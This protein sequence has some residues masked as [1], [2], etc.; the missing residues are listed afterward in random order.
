MLYEQKSL[1][2]G[3]KVDEPARVRFPD[4]GLKYLIGLE[5][6]NVNGHRL[7]MDAFYPKNATEK[8]PAVIWIHGGG[9]SSEE[10]TRFY[11]PEVQLA[12]LARQGFFVASIDYRL[13]QQAIFPAQIEDCKCA[14]RYL[15]AHA[16]EYGI[17]KDHIAVWGESAGGHL[18]GLMACT[19]GYAP[20]EGNGGWENESSDVQA[21]VPWY[22]PVELK[23][24]EGTLFERMFGGM[25]E[26]AQALA[27]AASPIT[28]AQKKDLPPMLLMHGN[29]D[30]IVS[31]SNSEE[32]L[33][34]ALEVNNPVR[35]ITVINQGHGFF[36]GDE[37]YQAIYDFLW[38][39]LKGKDRHAINYAGDGGH[40]VFY[41]PTDWDKEGVDYLKDVTYSHAGGY[42]L[43]MDIFL[44]R[45]GKK[46]RPTVLW[47]HGGGLRSEEL[48]RLYR[49][50]E[51]MLELLKRGFVVASADYRL[52]QHTPFP[53]Q[54]A[55]PRC[56]I[57]YLRAHADEY[58][59]DKENLGTW[60]ESAGGR[61]TLWTAVGE[62]IPQFD[63]GTEW[64]EES[65][66]V[67]CAC[68]WYGGS[69][70]VKQAEL[71][72]NYVYHTLAIPYDYFGE[73]AK[74]FYETSPI[75]YAHKKLPP[76]LLMHGTADPLVAPWHSTDLYAE[77]IEGGNDAEL[78]MVPGQV[79][80]FFTGKPATDKVISFF[81]KHLK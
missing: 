10:L 2:P 4:L 24:R 7:L 18:A 22:M 11:R 70:N 39:T 5:Y 25:D 35:L 32:F 67:K 74:L 1:L 48:T 51:M 29:R 66:L 78:M 80:G 34:A 60:G 21:A 52:L 54:I 40:V 12:E 8:L 63:N 42:D 72:G 79:H 53:A 14:V 68:A 23:P 47:F 38:K 65:S 64:A 81:E 3:A 46:N 20:F 13:I 59:I 57:R 43:K 75:A 28:Y 44:P 19:N 33:K 27:K 15:R 26:K 37:Y 69:N 9:W 61:I 50:E 56:A 16:D 6:G 76:I 77:L 45:D 62:Y 49:P 55:D 17:D 30:S 36:D 73:G 58:G 31:H 71:T 41:V